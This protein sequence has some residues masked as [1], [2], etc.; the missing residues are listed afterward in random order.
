MAKFKIILSDPDNGTS[1]IID[2]EGARAVPLVGRKLGETLDG[3]AIGLGG[4]KLKITGGSDIDGFPMRPDIHGGVKAK[5]ILTKG[6][7]F[8]SKKQGD[9]RRKTVRGCVIT[10]EIVQINMKIAEKPRTAEHKPPEKAQAKEKQKPEI[11][12]KTKEAERLTKDENKRPLKNEEK[13]ASKEAE[14]ESNAI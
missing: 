8:H 2:L 6:L 14:S 5:I 7:G 12:E 4:H 13:E 11:T 9:R 3:A 10:E 1:Q